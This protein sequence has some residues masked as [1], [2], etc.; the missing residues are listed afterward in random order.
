MITL[1]IITTIFILVSSFIV[2]LCGCYNLTLK[3]GIEHIVNKFKKKQEVYPWE[4]VDLSGLELNNIDCFG[5]VDPVNTTNNDGVTILLKG[6]TN[7]IGP[8]NVLG[9]YVTNDDG[10]I[11]GYL[12]DEGYAKNSSGEIFGYYPQNIPIIQRPAAS[13]FSIRELE[14]SERKSFK[15]HRN[16][17]KTKI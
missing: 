6:T 15:L 5:G 2:G 4:N 11:I 10:R 17:K 14:I 16:K 7:L 1:L 13:P 12:D 8:E 3:Q 9:R